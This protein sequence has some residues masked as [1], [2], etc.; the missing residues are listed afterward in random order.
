MP[1]AT[2]SAGFLRTRDGVK[3]LQ[4]PGSSFTQALGINNHDEVVRSYTDGNGNMRGFRYR[5]G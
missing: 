4:F 3:A 5:D 1:S 2:T